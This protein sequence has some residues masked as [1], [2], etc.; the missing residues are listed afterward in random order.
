[1]VEISQRV[2]Q[3]ERQVRGYGL[4][5]L[6]MP[7]KGLAACVVAEYVNAYT[8]IRA[9]GEADCVRRMYR[10]MGRLAGLMV[11][12]F[13]EAECPHRASSWLAA[14]DE[15]GEAAGD[16][17]LDCWLR[18]LAVRTAYERGRY[19]EALIIAGKAIQIA[20][21]T[22]GAVL[23][24]ATQAL[25]WAERGESSRALASLKHADDSYARLPATDTVASMLCYPRGLRHHHRGQVYAVLGMAPAGRLALQAALRC[26]PTGALRARTEVALDLVRCDG[27][28]TDTLERLP[29]V[30]R[31]ARLARLA[32]RLEDQ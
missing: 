23:A 12:L 11:M 20:P 25:A 22:V 27:H 6:T 24:E 15:A 18:A 3:T 26:Y 29:A 16:A 8:L 2:E 13:N 32:T 10:A 1:V 30:H 4:A 14:A 17:E 28:A 5:Y 21:D 31:T 7:P 9:G 19:T